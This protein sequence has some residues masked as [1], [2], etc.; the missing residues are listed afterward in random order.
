M[1]LSNMKTKFRNEISI[2]GYDLSVVKSAL[3]KYIRRNNVEMALKMCME[4]YYFDYVEGGKR[5]L[6]NGLHRLQIIFLEDIGCG[7]LKLWGQLVEWFDEIYKE[8]DREGGVRN[9]E[10]EIRN[11][12]KIVVNLCKSRKIRCGSFMNAISVI[13]ENKYDK[14][15]NC[16]YIDNFDGLITIEQ[17]DIYLKNKSW[18]SIVVLR[19]LLFKLNELKRKEKND[20]K[21]NLDSVLK[22]YLNNDYLNYA[23]RWEKDIGKL[24]EGFLLYFVPLCDYLYGSD[25]LQLYD[26]ETC[27][28]VWNEDWIGKV[29]LDDYIYDK[30]VK[31]AKNISMEYF[32]NVSSHVE[33]K[34]EDVTMPTAFETIYKWLKL[35]D[36]T[37][38]LNFRKM[39]VWK[40]PKNESELDFICRAQL[41][42]SMSKTDTY[43][44]KGINN[45]LN[46]VWLVKGPYSDTKQIE[47]F[48]ELQKIK[49]KDGLNSIKAFMVKMKVDRW[50]ELPGI[51]LRHKFKVDDDGYFMLSKSIIKEDEL[52][53][54]EHP[55]S[56]KWGPTNVVDLKK[57]SVNV[58]ELNDLQMIDYLNNIGF[59][60]KHNLGDFADRNFIVVGDKVY[61]VDE[62]KTVNKV[63]LF[64][65]LKKNKYKYVSDKFNALKDKLLPNN[66][67]SSLYFQSV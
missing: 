62:N 9:R 40:F 57:F 60:L 22:T 65:E 63:N 13:N 17:L 67:I 49:K 4:I 66:K 19:K 31:G 24:K 15:K 50:A 34:S 45:D 52:N 16:K 28:G 23:G 59:R 5:I 6:T 42:T 56:K 38:L 55:G 51:G 47:E 30:H 36:K 25:A 44:A 27:D 8:R 33:P 14:I 29:E 39:N 43:Y 58:F 10:I 37:V 35:D 12:K 3:Q 26:D 48:I 11:L 46:Q 61:S 21:K 64:N 32:A 1:D 20:M 2:S 53:I 7:N 41:V 54:I 18:K